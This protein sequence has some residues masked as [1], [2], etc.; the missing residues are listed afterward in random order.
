MSKITL[1]LTTGDTTKISLQAL[2]INKNEGKSFKFYSVEPYP[3]EEVRKI[4]DEDFELIDRKL[5]EVEIDLLSTADLLFI[6]SSH[7][8]KIDSDVNYEIL[9]I[10]PKLKVG[11]LIHWHDIV[12]PSNYWKDVIDSGLTRYG[13]M[14]W[15]KPERIPVI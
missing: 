6:D 3:R 7:V 11:A 13:Q 8:S 4:Q 10:I 5:Q 1:G 2:Q 14:L 9:E 12:I 15:I